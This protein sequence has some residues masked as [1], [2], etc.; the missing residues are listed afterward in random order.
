MTVTLSPYEIMRAVMLGVVMV[1]MGKVSISVRLV[2]V[3]IMVLVS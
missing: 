1:L 3:L 2:V